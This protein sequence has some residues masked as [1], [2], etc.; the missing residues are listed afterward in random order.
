MVHREG[1]A[2]K[3]LW[4]ILKDCPIVCLEV[5]RMNVITSLETDFKPS[6]LFES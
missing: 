4:R 3:H 5:Q 1:R 2:E 6:I